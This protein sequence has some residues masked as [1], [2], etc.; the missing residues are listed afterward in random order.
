MADFPKHSLADWAAL[1]ARELGDRPLDALTQV[2]A[3]GIAV[4]P[5]YSAADLAGLDAVANL[6]GFPPYLRGPRA[7]MYANRPWTVRQ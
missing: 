4:K 5:L 2:T 3:E 1:A 7:T 6:P